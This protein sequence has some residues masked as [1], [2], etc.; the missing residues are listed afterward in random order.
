MTK[1]FIVGITGYARSGKDTAAEALI[2][3][4][5][6]KRIAFADA[7]RRDMQVLDP[8]IQGGIRLSDALRLHDGDLDEIKRAYPEYRRLLQVYGTEV[9]RSENVDIWVDRA[10]LTISRDGLTTKQPRYVIP[11]VRFLNERARVPFDVVLRV[12][13]PGVGPL[14]GHSS[15]QY[16]MDIPVDEVLYNDD[17][18]DTLHVRTLKAV[19][20]RGLWE[21]EAKHA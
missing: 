7:M 15:E 14:N 16:V 2:A 6:F 21:L 9:W 18:I 8:Y 17:T 10:I 12:D 19:L 1:P 20:G 5:G 3:S 4:L 11:D 13:R